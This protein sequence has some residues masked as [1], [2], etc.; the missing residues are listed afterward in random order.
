MWVGHWRNFGEGPGKMNSR[1]LGVFWK[2]TER[3]MHPGWYVL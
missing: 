3:V 2:R 1:V